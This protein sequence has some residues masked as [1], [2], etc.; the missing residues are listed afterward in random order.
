MK[1]IISLFVVLTMLMS[2][3]INI[4]VNAATYTLSETTANYILDTISSEYS[5][6]LSDE[7]KDLMYDSDY[8]DII[9][10]KTT[11]RNYSTNGNTKSW[12]ISNADNYGT[13]VVDRGETVN[14]GWGS[15]GCMSYAC[16]F[17]YSIY[18][19][20][21]AKNSESIYLDKND[22]Q[23][24]ENLKSYIDENVQP[25]E[26]L[27]INKRHS[28]IYLCDGN[29]NGAE[30]FY[31]A[32]YWGGAKKDENGI[33]RFNEKNDQYYINFYTYESFVKAYSGY[34]CFVYDAYENSVYKDNTPEDPETP[35][36]VASTR[37]IV[38]VLDI[39]TSMRGTKITNT[40]VASKMFVDQILDNDHNTRIALVIYGSYVTTLL[41]LSD[42]KE[43]IKNAI[44]S[45][46]LT[47]STNM[48]G[49]LERAGEILEQSTADK[50]AVVIMTDGQANTGTSGQSGYRTV[51]EG[52][53]VYFGSYDVA[54]YDL[55]QDYVNNKNYAIYSLGFGL[56]EYSSEINLMKYIAS[57]DKKGE[58]YFWSVTNEN[59]DD[60]I[61]TYEDIAD[62]IV[63]K[64][65]IIISIEC[66]VEVEISYNGETLNKDNTLT[67][68]GSVTV[69]QVEDG[70]SYLFDVEDNRDYDINIVGTDEGTMSFKISYI[71][72]DTEVYREFI[73]VPV[74][75][76]TQIST[77]ATD[78]NADFALYVD[79]DG[80]GTTD[81]GW[82]AMANETVTASSDEIME[83]L[84]P[85]ESIMDEETA[86][87]AASPVGGTYT[88]KQ[89]V[90]LTAEPDDAA[91]YYTIDG[92]EPTTE[93]TLYTEAIVVSKTTTIKAIAVKEGFV[94]SDVLTETYKIKSSS[95]G[96]GGG[97]GGG[98]STSSYT[99]KFETN[100]GSKIANKSVSKKKTLAEPTAP[101]KE[102]YTFDGWYTD[103]E[104][105]EKYDFSAEVTKGFT[106]YAKWTKK[107]EVN[108]DDEKNDIENT[109]ANDSIF[110][111]VNES[112]WFYEAVKFAFENGI[113][114]GV[115]ANM[116][117][118]NDKVTRGQFITML[119]RAYGIKEMTGENFDD[120]GDTW[121]TGY[122]AAAKQAGISKGIGDNKFAPEREITREEMVT[123]IYNYLKA[124]GKAIAIANEPSFDDNDAIS[125]WA[126]LG[127]AFASSKGYVKGKGNNMFD[128]K[129]HATR[130]ELAQ[131]FYNIL[132]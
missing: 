112:D 128:P 96:G 105:T 35:E 10:D 51:A 114:S 84:F 95:G 71:E 120:C 109:E 130:A 16:F 9:S 1:K 107:V 123:L 53:E 47:G 82:S 3:F 37:D 86:Y 126:K 27:R 108:A 90:V 39:S 50:K 26:H 31:I 88:K 74:T 14:W 56:S 65:N 36:P 118:P 121:Y 116:F 131:I 77:S 43:T 2:L 73:D 55:A 48:C 8:S 42:D 79:S 28:V 7:I 32:E 106:L 15:A 61:F 46:N 22:S 125:D 89:N 100:G 34:T 91:I 64:K 17:T 68:F 78:R 103:A 76:N 38:L 4:N 18:G 57:F 99:V 92:S 44:D 58:R 115:S 21:G 117:A 33:Y 41:E 63:T 67:S 113:T 80:D 97:G 127:V 45:I 60:I 93:S 29:E 85:S 19:T 52:D 25:G 111:D 70:N 129:G 12:P 98:G 102:G 13:F 69:T 30:G 132:K 104:L 87:V 83:Q 6:E 81:E 54:I 72:G 94:N 62:T 66:P 40:K 119:C 110:A 122:L 49:G 124:E 20:I 59:I 101:T 11:L 23:T 24:W 75:S 5:Q